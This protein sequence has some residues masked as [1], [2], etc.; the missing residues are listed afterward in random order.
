M[1]RRALASLVLTHAELRASP[2]AVKDRF[3]WATAMQR[4]SPFGLL[5]LTGLNA[6]A[7]ACHNMFDKCCSDLHFFPARICNSQD[8]NLEPFRGDQR[9]LQKATMSHHSKAQSLFASMLRLVFFT[10]SVRAKKVNI[11]QLPFQQTN[12]DSAANDVKST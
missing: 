3:F 11:G 1:A 2:C 10:L 6:Y 8:P 5:M 4:Q 12:W 9:T 7:M